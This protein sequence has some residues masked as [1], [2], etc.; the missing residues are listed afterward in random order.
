LDWK[1][2][3]KRRYALNPGRPREKMVSIVE[4]RPAS[5]ALKLPWTRASKTIG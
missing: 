2:L 1:A 3:I 4:V 5:A